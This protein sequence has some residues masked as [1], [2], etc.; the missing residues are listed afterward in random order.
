MCFIKKNCVI[1]NSVLAPI[2]ELNR[3]FTISLLLGVLIFLCLGYVKD[4]NAVQYELSMGSYYA[5]YIGMYFLDLGFAVLMVGSVLPTVRKFERIVSNDLL[6]RINEIFATSSLILFMIVLY[7]TIFHPA[8]HLSIMMIVW[9]YTFIYYAFVWLFWYFGFRYLNSTSCRLR[10]F[11][12][13]RLH[14]YVQ[15]LV[16]FVFFLIVPLVLFMHKTTLNKYLA[17]TAFV[18]I[19]WFILMIEEH[20]NKK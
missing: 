18:L 9:F 17:L 1:F 12:E 2:R 13:S 15:G 10:V 19:I 6:S 4:V 20:F 7:N 16:Y 14:G 11:L 5:K 8:G 3:N